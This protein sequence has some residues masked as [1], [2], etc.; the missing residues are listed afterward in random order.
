MPRFLQ[1]FDESLDGRLVLPRGLAAL[2]ASTV[3]AA[4]SAVEIDDQRAA[5]T[6]Q[7]FDLAELR[8]DV[9]V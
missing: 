9:G 3:A 8:L 7:R 2:V 5:S 6:P 4:G 1:S